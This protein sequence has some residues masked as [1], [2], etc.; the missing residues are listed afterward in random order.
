MLTTWWMDG[1]PYAD[2]DIII[3]DGAV[4]A[5]KTIIGTMSF[6]MWAMYSFN[7]Q[8]FGIAGKGLDI[9]KRNVWVPMQ[10]WFADIHMQVIRL[11]DTANGYILRY[12]YHDE[13]GQLIQKENYFYLFG[14]RDASSESVVRGMT[15]A[16][17]LFDE[18]PLMPEEFVNQA[19]LRCS[20]EGAKQWFFCNPEGPQ[21]WFKL[22]WVDQITKRNGLRIRFKLEDNPSLSERTIKRYKSQWEGVWYSR[23]IDGEWA[24]AE[25][26][27]YEQYANNVESFY[28]EKDDL[29]NYFD[30]LIIG[31]DWGDSNSAHSFSATGITDNFTKVWALASEKHD[32]KDLTPTKVEQLVIKFVKRIIKEYKNVDFIFADHI[33]TYINGVRVALQKENIDVSISRATKSKVIERILTTIRLMCTGRFKLVRGETDTLSEAFTAAVWDPD[34]KDKAERL[35][36]GTSDIDSLDSHEY[37][38]TP[39][40][41]MLSLYD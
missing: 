14:G 21:H 9:L 26:L 2:K 4:R 29:P 38:W 24:I 32:A 10:Q 37:T 36:D 16:G 41:E 13:D 35:D 17:F 25:G 22:K 8:N 18:A 1:S 7:G 34:V 12:S 3:A 5:G 20:V 33:N 19:I 30:K 15:A 40:I 28:V 31:I 11:R 27:I 39:Y 6:I 23:F